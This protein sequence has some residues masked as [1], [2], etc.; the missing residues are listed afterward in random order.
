MVSTRSSYSGSSGSAGGNGVEVPVRKGV[1]VPETL[2]VTGTVGNLGTRVVILNDTS[3]EA[4]AIGFAEY[5]ALSMSIVLYLPSVPCHS[6][7]ILLA[8][9]VS[10]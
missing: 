3:P 9:P 1:D 7:A 6:M 10:E 5:F 8:E 2:G 4:V